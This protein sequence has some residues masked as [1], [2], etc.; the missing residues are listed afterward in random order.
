V[1]GVASQ[2][3]IEHSSGVNLLLAIAFV[4]MALK[5]RDRGRLLPGMVWLTAAAAGLVLMLAIPVVFHIENNHTDTYRSMNLG[6]ISAI[7]LSCAKNAIQLSNHH[8]GACTFPMCFGAF[9]TVYMTR[10]RRSEK[11][12]RLL[13]GINAAALI[14]L[15]LSLMLGLGNYLGKSALIQHVFSGMFA[16]VPYV[17]WVIAA[18]SLEDVVFRGKLLVILAFALISLVPL[19]VV[20]PIPARVVF[21]AH[22]FV[23]LGAMLCFG[24][25]RRGLPGQWLAPITRCAVAVA[26]TLA[27]LL[28]SV[29]VSIR[30]MSQIREEH[31]R[32]ELDKGATEIVIFRLPYDYTSWDH[33]WA[34]K[35]YNDTDR[36]V[37]FS[38]ISFALWMNDLYS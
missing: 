2:L 38:S 36:E 32:R 25:L 30:F 13:G 34:Q 22:I 26:L 9:A 33:L 16:L 27:V 4:F 31:I 29:F 5:D 11:A 12:N 6:S 24:E 14:Y 35:Y 28:G 37:S 15:I 18:F 19:L 1:L 23:I 17:V 3:F 20:T 10:S 8:F 21:Q 7:V